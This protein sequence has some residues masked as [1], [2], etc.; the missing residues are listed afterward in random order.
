MRKIVSVMPL[1]VFGRFVFGLIATFRLLKTADCWD[2]IILDPHTI[3][4]ALPIVLLRQLRKGMPL[5]LLRVAT[6]P[7]PSEAR[8]PKEDKTTFWS[9]AQFAV[10]AKLAAKCF[11]RIFFVSP[12]LAQVSSRQLHLPDAKVSVWPACVDLHT[13]NPSSTL[14]T[15]AKKLRDELGLK[16]RL[17][18]LYHGTISE[19]R[20]TRELVTAFKLL[21]KERMPV[22]LI[23]LSSP[24]TY[25]QEII[26][27]VQDN[28]L[29]DTVM[30]VGPVK[31]SEVPNFIAASDVGIVPLPDRIWWRYQCPLKLLEYLA[32][33]LPVIVSDLPAH[34]WIIGQ[35]NVGL[36]L[37]GTRPREI[38]QGIR[39]FLKSRTV[40]EPYLGRKIVSSFSASALS[41]MIESEIYSLIGL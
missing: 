19:S 33:N 14:K 35:A 22:T 10:A 27:Y 26:R 28:H 2:A 31:Y 11:D 3:V 6:S 38:A 36:Y 13:F 25:R 8:H 9:R 15:K 39:D 30:V 29:E 21:K 32:M 4:S 24:S 18:V 40:L 20:G 12:M 37:A 16:H 1:F 23:L 41:R 34:R 7:V 5:L 17:G